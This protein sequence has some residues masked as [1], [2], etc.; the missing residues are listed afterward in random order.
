MMIERIYPWDMP[1]KTQ[2][3]MDLYNVGEKEAVK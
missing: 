1:E 3:I 2:R